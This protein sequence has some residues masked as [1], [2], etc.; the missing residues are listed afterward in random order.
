MR[1]RRWRL[2]TVALVA[3]PGAR[4]IPSCFPASTHRCDTFPPAPTVRPLSRR[5]QRSLRGPVAR[6]YGF[7]DV[8]S[9]FTRSRPSLRRCAGRAIAAFDLASGSEKTVIEDA[10]QPAVLPNGNLLFLRGDA[11][12]SVAFDA[13]TL[14]PRGEPRVVVPSVQSGANSLI[15]QYA[16]GGGRLLY[17]PG[18]NTTRKASHRGRMAWHHRRPASPD[19]RTG[20]VSRPSL[21]A[22]RPASRVFGVGASGR[23]RD[24]LVRVRPAARCEDS[25]G[26]RPD[27]AEWRPVWTSDGRFIVF[28]NFS[29]S[30]P[31]NGIHRIRADGSGQPEQLTTATTPAPCRCPCR[32]RRMGSTSRTRN[33]RETNRRTSGFFR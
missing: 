6:R 17:L 29:P 16:T 28:S 10:A 12:Y 26:R 27:R 1:C 4:T 2:S 23:R 30:K 21:L 5:Y 18:Q 11:L 24:R 31:S 20:H 8:E 13:D 9:S 32:S 15:S 25:T 33:R 3:P 22:R 19:Q 7:P 14:S